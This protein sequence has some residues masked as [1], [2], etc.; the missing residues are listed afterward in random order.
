MV[1]DVATPSPQRG[2]LDQVLSPPTLSIPRRNLY[3]RSKEREQMVQ[4]YDRVCQQQSSSATKS[5]ERPKS[6]L[7]AILGDSGIGKTALAHSLYWDVDRCRNGQGFFVSGK[8][9]QMQ[10]PEPYEGFVEAFTQFV[11]IVQDRENGVANVRQ[12][13]M[14]NGIDLEREGKMLSDT[15]PAMEHI[16]VIQEPQESV[17]D[18]AVTQQTS[19]GDGNL[20]SKYIPNECSAAALRF[21]HVF[22]SFIQAVTSP[23]YPLVLVMDDL[24]WADEASLELLR[25]LLEDSLLENV[26]FVVTFRSDMTENIKKLSAFSS[27]LVES[28]INVT[29]I[30]I[31]ALEC[32]DIQ[33][34]LG[35][36]LRMDQDEAT[37]LALCIHKHTGGNG[38]HVW[39][40]LRFIH[41]QNILQYDLGHCDCDFQSVEQLLTEIRDMDRL[42]LS[43]LAGIPEHVLELIKIASCLGSKVDPEILQYFDSQ[44]IETVLKQATINDTFVHDEKRNSWS[45]AHDVVQETIYK[46]MIEPGER[47]GFHYRI[48]RKLWRAL[49]EEKLGD[50]IIP[51]L[52]QLLIASDLWDDERERIAVARL[53]LSA[54]LKGVSLSTFRTALFYLHKGIVLLGLDA[55]EDNY[56]LWLELHSAAAEVA[57]SL[58]DHIS[59]YEHA[60]TVVKH[61]NSFHDTLRASTARIRALGN[62]GDHRQAVDECLEFLEKL[63][64][65]ISLKPS[66]ASVALKWWMLLRRLKSRSNESILRLPDMTNPE[67]LAAMQVLN[68]MFVGAGFA[69][70]EMSPLIPLKMIQLTLDHGLSSVSCVGFALLGYV[71]AGMGRDPDEG[72]RFGQLGFAIYERFA[73]RAFLARLTALYFDGIHCWKHP[74]REMFGSLWNAYRVGLETGDVEFALLCAGLPSLSKFDIE[75]LPLVDKEMGNDRERMVLHQ[76]FSFDLITRPVQQ[77]AQNL[78]GRSDDPTILRGEVFDDELAKKAEQEMHPAHFWAKTHEVLLCCLFEKYTKAKECAAVSM[79]IPKRDYGPLH[80]SVATFACAFAHVADARERK[81][82]HAA[83]MAKRG[84]QTLYR[85]SLHSSENYLGKHLLLEAE[86]AALR[87][88]KSTVV[89]YKTAIAVLRQGHYLLYLALANERLALYLHETGNVND[90]KPYFRD[91]LAVYEEWGALAK[92]NQ[93]TAKIHQMIK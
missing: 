31:E 54:G 37:N 59:T 71:M 9:G 55:W 42:V 32:M 88:E 7:I 27:N 56:E 65:E 61:A 87:H 62:R 28:S 36:E 39:E 17:G 91:A 48:G 83:R 85:W 63:G 15:I 20:Q 52:G 75:P 53:C 2:F 13:M 93:L 26:L 86:L 30:N 76:Q 58:G 19:V 38:F 60:E 33:V 79:E 1:K 49:D 89:K 92:V 66:K 50:F 25:F 72:Y 45:F 73:A 11:E 22:R 77:S 44:P 67:H 70:D 4:A 41:K 3:G 12:A 43:K 8:F 51:V 35:K 82:R 21:K 64:I 16:L 40:V 69:S 74:A 23:S 81:Q 68:L 90:S 6:E 34:L 24:H 5:S 10:R 29:D 57:S 47:V 78:M 18:P 84:S 46:R 14:E 80:S